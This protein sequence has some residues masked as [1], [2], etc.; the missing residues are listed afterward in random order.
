MEWMEP[1]RASRPG[2][3]AHCGEAKEKRRSRSALADS[4]S[5][6]QAD[7]FTIHDYGAD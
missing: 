3:K 4:V 6:D 7:G 2:G 1:A 5:P